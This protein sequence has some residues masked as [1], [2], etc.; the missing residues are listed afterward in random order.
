[1][2]HRLWQLSPHGLHLAVFGKFFDNNEDEK[3]FFGG[4]VVLLASE[5]PQLIW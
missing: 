1:M 4:V 3:H 2:S 5:N